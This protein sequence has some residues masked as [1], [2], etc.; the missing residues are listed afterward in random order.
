MNDR[1]QKRQKLQAVLDSERSSSERN[2][3]GQFATP[4]MLANEI[5]QYVLGLHDERAISF[6]EPSCGSGAFI[7]AFYQ[8]TL[9]DERPKN[10]TG[11]ELDSRFADVSKDLWGPYGANVIEGDF[12]TD[13]LI[14]K[15]SVSLL[16][17]N[18]PYSRHH[19]LTSEKKSRLKQNIQHDLNM[20]PS[21]LSGLYLY[22]VLQAHKIL[23]PGAVSAW[24]IPSEF[25]DVN[26]GKT[27][28]EYLTQRVSLVRIHRFAPEDDQFADAM[29]T[30]SVV[31]FVNEPP[32]PDHEVELTLGNRISTPESI[33]KIKNSDLM[34]EHKWAPAFS[35]RT[36]RRS[37]NTPRFD[38]FFKI[39]RGIATGGNKFFILDRET[40]ID[41]GF[42]EENIIPVMP[43]SRYLKNDVVDTE[44]S[45]YP[46]GIPQLGLIYTI[47]PEEELKVIDSNLADYIANADEKI[48]NG[49]LVSKRKPWYRQ[50]ARDP[51]PFLLTYMGR[52]RDAEVQ[53]FRFI[54]NKSQ[55]IATNGFLMLYPI[56]KL[57]NALQAGQISLEEVHE[58]LKSITGD[59]FRDGGR[60]YSGGMHKVEPKE[61]AAMDATA[62]ES[63][64]PL[65]TVENEPLALF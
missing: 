26:F 17:A 44:E 14:E 4:P 31:I 55:A 19:H 5:M 58:V 1:E 18:P 16:V 62:I 2:K 22:F 56:G 28:K 32:T 6:V 27:L 37:E 12:L 57:E 29:V 25:L 38:E 53:P 52:S 33:C 51:A 7:S 64:I 30:S 59:D 54:L 8:N 21:G 43:S 60:I 49:Y 34:P 35:G 42:N 41:K 36:V 65:E 50:E 40:I 39:R 11:I 3:W 47:L 48:R 20:T 23:A 45:G 10:V 15:K 9:S 24:L 63:L 61:L 13:D 46:T